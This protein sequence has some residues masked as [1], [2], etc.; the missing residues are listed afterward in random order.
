[1]FV[2]LETEFGADHIEKVILPYCCLNT[3]T[4]IVGMPELCNSEL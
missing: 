2:T 1:M 4:E 3:K